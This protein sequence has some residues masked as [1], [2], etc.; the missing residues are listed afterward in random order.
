MAT[1][2]RSAAVART[3]AIGPR[4]TRERLCGFTRTCSSARRKRGS[5]WNGAC[6]SRVATPRH[7]R[8]LCAAR[9]P[10]ALP[11][12]AATE[13]AAQLKPSRARCRSRKHSPTSLARLARR[14]AAIWPR[15]KM[16]PA[17][18]RD[19]Q[20]ARDRRRTLLGDGS[21]SASPRRAGLSRRRRGTRR[22][23]EIDARL[24]D[25]EDRN[26]KHIVT[27]LG[28]VLP[29][30]ELL[31]E[32]LLQQ[33]QPA[34]AL[35]NSRPRRSASPTASATKPGPDGGRGH[36]C[37]KNKAAGTTRSSSS[38]EEGRRNRRAQARE[39]IRRAR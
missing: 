21:G 16:M 3:P 29:R 23:C 17:A 4:P 24:R 19:P 35:K 32:M 31:G 6:A 26:E 1:N 37:D 8:P 33:K 20:A 12:S 38:F 5:P 14:E 28:R 34:A 9:C 7:R 39:G 22:G 36:G 10:R 25:A 18:R 30:E 13:A 15:P 27:H 11:W 2:R